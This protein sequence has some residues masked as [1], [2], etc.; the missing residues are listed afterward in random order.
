MSYYTGQPYYVLSPEDYN[1]LLGLVSGNQELL[2]FLGQFS[3]LGGYYAYGGDDPL[4]Y[5]LMDETSFDIP[6]LAFILSTQSWA[7]DY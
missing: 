6:I 3:L 7:G 2:D 5:D 4:I 1:T